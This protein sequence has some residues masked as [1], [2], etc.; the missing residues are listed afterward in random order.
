MDNR[1][2]HNGIPKSCATDVKKLLIE[3]I[4]EDVDG[5]VFDLRDNGGGSLPDCVELTGYFIEDGPIVQVQQ[6]NRR[7]RPL[8]DPNRDIVYK[9]PMVVLVNRQSASA[10][11]IFAAALQ[12][13]GRAIIIGDTKTHGKGSVQTLYPLDRGNYKMGSLKVTTAGFF[14]ID[15]R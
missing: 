11:E 14:R 1:D 15:G 4:K 8:M 2:G 13:Y 12:D 9:G 5:I 6:T 7:P 10:S 3:L